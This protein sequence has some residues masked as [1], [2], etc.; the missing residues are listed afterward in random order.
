MAHVPGDLTQMPL[1]PFTFVDVIPVKAALSSKGTVRIAI[2][3]NNFV[4][5]GISQNASSQQS[6]EESCAAL[7][8]P[9]CFSEGH[10]QALEALLSCKS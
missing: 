9:P 4:S 6:N 3:S 2:I 1:H 10:S 5:V 8:E 7:K